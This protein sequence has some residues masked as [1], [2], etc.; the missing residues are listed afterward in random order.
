M[1]DD[2]TKDI[3]K[4]MNELFKDITD[5][6]NKHGIDS[7]TFIVGLLSYC[8][9]KLAEQRIKRLRGVEDDL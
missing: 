6:Q 8:Q 5:V 4:A 1:I 2:E 9:L 3:F 7:D